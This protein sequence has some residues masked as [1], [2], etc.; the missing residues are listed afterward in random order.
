M[1]SKTLFRLKKSY[2]A[3]QK[4]DREDPDAVQALVKQRY[5]RR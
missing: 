1:S 2:R 4:M 5:A 3:F